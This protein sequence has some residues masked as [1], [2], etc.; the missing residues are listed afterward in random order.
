MVVT[1]E[2]VTM[3]MVGMMMMMMAKKGK[4]RRKPH[5]WLTLKQS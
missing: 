3:T 2:K 4:G 1:V 5:L